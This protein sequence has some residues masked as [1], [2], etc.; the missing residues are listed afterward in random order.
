MCLALSTWEIQHYK[1][2]QQASIFNE[3]IFL[4]KAQNKQD[5]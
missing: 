2:E 5:I 1:N 3:L 4:V